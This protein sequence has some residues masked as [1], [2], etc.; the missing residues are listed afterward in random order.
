VPVHDVDVERA[1]T[2]VQ[3]LD[4]WLRNAPKSADRIDGRTSV[5]VGQLTARV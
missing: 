2:G 4:A 3:P 5:S 1:G